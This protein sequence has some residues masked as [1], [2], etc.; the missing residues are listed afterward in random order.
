M[1]CRLDIDPAIGP[2]AALLATLLLTSLLRR[3][4]R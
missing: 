3:R 4:Q 2:H 1:R